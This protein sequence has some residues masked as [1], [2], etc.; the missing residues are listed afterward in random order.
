MDSVVFSVLALSVL[1]CS[2]H[3]DDSAHIT[4]DEPGSAKASCEFKSDEGGRSLIGLLSERNVQKAA[5]SKEY[6]R[7]KLEGVLSSSVSETL[8]YVQSDDVSVFKRENDGMGCSL[9]EK[10]PGMPSGVSQYWEGVQ[11]ELS[12]TTAVA[13]SSNKLGKDKVRVMG[14][15]V[16]KTSNALTE[17]N[18]TKPFIIVRENSTRWTLVHEFMHH[19]FMTSALEKGHDDQKMHQ[20]W[21][22]AMNKLKGFTSDDIKTEYG[23]RGATEAVVDYAAANDDLLIHSYLEEMTIEDQLR[24]DYKAGRLQFVTEYDYQNAGWY[25][26]YSAKNFSQQMD[27]VDK[28]SSTLRKAILDSELSLGKQSNLLEKLDPI[29]KLVTQRER[30]VAEI[31]D[32]NPVDDSST[33]GILQA[34]QPHFHAPCDH[35]MDPQ[36][37]IELLN[38]IN[39]RLKGEPSAQPL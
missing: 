18:E 38:K 13:S 29:D 7:S 25:I 26:R 23:L 3:S 32:R 31:R 37:T 33:T 8:S 36:E 22:A 17:S 2:P 15:Y 14:V 16:G 24:A 39:S 1:G 9:Y 27:V 20:K 28:L 12:L 35:S 30:Q 5:F 11:S 19:L 10:A 4:P 21:K 34:S 6:N